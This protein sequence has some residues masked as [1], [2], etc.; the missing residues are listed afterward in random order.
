[1]RFSLKTLTLGVA[2]A[3]FMASPA[4]AGTLTINTD[5][6][7]PAPQKAFQYLIDA[8]QKANPD[9]KVKWN[10]FDHEG[11]KT[12]IRN[13]LTADAPDLAQLVCRQPHGALR[14][15]RSVRR[16]HPTS[17]RRTISTSS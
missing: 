15:G 17:G 7:D 11:Y 14:Q 5:T 8:F 16:C 13:F 12:A 4:L 9:I 2:A 1:M 10:N 6:S 3:A